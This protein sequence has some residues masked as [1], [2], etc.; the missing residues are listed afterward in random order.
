MIHHKIFSLSTILTAGLLWVSNAWC[1]HYYLSTSG[2]D[3]DNGSLTD[4][5]A[6]L[7]FSVNQL[8]PGDTLY[9]RGGIYQGDGDVEIDVSGTNGSPITII[10]YQNEKPQFYGTKVIDNGW[11]D[12]GAGIWSRDLSLDG[13]VLSDLRAAL[14]FQ[15]TKGSVGGNFMSSPPDPMNSL[16]ELTG[17]GMWYQSGTTLYVHPKDM[18]AGG[19]ANDYTFEIGDIVNCI[20]DMNAPFSSYLHIEGLTFRG[21]T[22]VTVNSTYAV[23]KPGALSFANASSTR[24]DI[25]LANN[26]FKQNFRGFRMGNI[27]NFTVSESIFLE[28]IAS[29]FSFGLTNGFVQTGAL[30]ED[31][32]FIDTHAPWPEKS[33]DDKNPA[34][35]KLHMLNN[36]TVQGCTI[37][38]VLTNRDNDYP[39]HG[40]WLDKDVSNV[41]V[42]NNFVAH[43]DGLEAAFLGGRGIFIERRC[44]DIVVERNV[45]YDCTKGIVIGNL[46]Q[47]DTDW[48]ESAEILHNTIVDSSHIGI[49]INGVDSATL[50]NNLVIGDSLSQLSASADS[51]DYIQ[52][53]SGGIHIDYNNLWEPSPPGA[54]LYYA[55]RGVWSTLANADDAAVLSE[56]AI[57]GLGAM[58]H[59]D[60]L[61]KNSGARDFRLRAVSGSVDVGLDWGQPFEGTAP[62]LGA[63]EISSVNI[64]GDIDHDGISD[65][66][67]IGGTLGFFT[68]PFDADSDD[69]GFQDG[70]EVSLNSNPNSGG[71]IPTVWVD[72]GWSGTESG[73]PSEPYSDFATA[74][75][76]LSSGGTVSL[77]GASVETESDWIGSIAVPL[78]MNAVGG[79]ILLGQTP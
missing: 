55:G 71:S 43:V 76:I 41:T 35:M 73:T 54:G 17:P 7:A 59:E 14:V 24:T 22:G 2:S 78:R 53:L 39:A 70:Y 6:T 50:L 18:G 58:I 79:S 20:R 11:I 1:T 21:Y 27:N 49:W 69:D 13:F 36:A 30:I 26:I 3:I 66:D 52:N 34:A 44:D 57:S 60:P 32:S 31:C 68:D 28:N 40:I 16:G 25:T 64:N 29:G 47:P 33:I 8:T 56:G 77:N 15:N 42:K 38:G 67:E 62:D 5:W 23:N 75:S 4:P 74:L 72:F 9:I 51:L 48:P 63:L 10:N 37:D 61:F 46:G 45:I 65:R 12:N 19:N